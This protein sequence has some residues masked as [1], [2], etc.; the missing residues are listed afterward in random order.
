MGPTNSEDAPKGTIR[1]D[2]G[3]DIE[4][5]AVHGSDAPGTAKLEIDY[6]FNATEICAPV[7][8]LP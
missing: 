8:A 6:F 7:E 2:L 3:I 5:N 4:R 1:G